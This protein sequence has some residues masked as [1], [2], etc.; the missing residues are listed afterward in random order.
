MKRET[1]LVDQQISEERPGSKWN[2][3]D[4]TENRETIINNLHLRKVLGW[5]G[6]R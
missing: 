5:K 4:Q 1:S 2:L 6:V 3:E